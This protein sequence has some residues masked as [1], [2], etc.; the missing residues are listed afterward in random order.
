MTD[1]RPIGLGWVHP[2]A[3]APDWDMAQV[4]RLA[5]RLGYRLVWAPE[6]SW[7]PLPDQ[8]RESG[9]EAVIAPSTAHFDPLTLNAVMMVADVETVLPRLSFARWTTRSPSERNR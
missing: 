9:A 3:S 7:I 1:P 4:R 2:E 5:S 8:V 6:T